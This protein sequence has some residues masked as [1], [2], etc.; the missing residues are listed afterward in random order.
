MKPNLPPTFPEAFIERYASIL[1]AV[2]LERIL[3]GFDAKRQTWFRI[4]LLRGTIDSAKVIL[5]EDGVK[6]IMDEFLVDAGWVEAEDRESLLSSKA[7]QM[8]LIYVQGLASQLPVRFLD[9]HPGLSVLDLTAAPGSKTLQ[10]AGLASLDDEIAAVEL[11]RKRKFKL[12]D[13]LRRHG[14]D[15]VR[16]FLQDGTKVWKYR[17]EYF[18]RVLLDAPCSSEGRFRLDD[19]S[20]F[21]YWSPSKVK[22]MV[23][24]QRRL[25]FSAVHALR[26][27]GTLVYSTCAV[28]PDE[29]EGA[30]EHILKSFEGCIKIDPIK[31]DAPE[32]V[33]PVLKWR[34]KQLNDQVAG[35]CRLVPSER[36]EGFFV[37]KMIK[38]DTSHPPTPGKRN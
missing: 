33:E 29:N 5:I 1:G 27:G 9:I 13:N 38:T 23:R 6:F 18:D 30:I 12:Q 15:H 11:V 4:N 2:Q 24:K 22:E 7:A 10:I 35:A 19:E 17:P 14:A 34:N 21:S 8:G 25:L 3:H 36:M 26:P 28:S 37:C 16:V 20:S 31:F 32:R